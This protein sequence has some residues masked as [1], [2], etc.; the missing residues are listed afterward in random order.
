MVSCTEEFYCYLDEFVFDKRDAWTKEEQQTNQ[1]VPEGDKVF[2]DAAITARHDTYLQDNKPTEPPYEQGGKR[3]YD[4]E[5]VNNYLWNDQ[6]GAWID[7][8]RTGPQGPKGQDGS[9]RILISIDPPVA[10]PNGEPLES[11]DI[12]FNNCSAETWIYYQPDKDVPGNWLSFGTGGIQGQQGPIGNYQAIIGLCAP[13]ERPSGQPLENGDI[14]FNTC[15]GEAFWYFDGQ[16]IN[17]TAN[18][19]KGDT[20]FLKLFV[21]SLLQNVEKMTH[22]YSVVTSGSTPVLVRCM[23]V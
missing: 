1:V 7:Y 22:L 21:L 23:S 15:I 20:G 9:Y 14:W 12:W 10:R 5:K 6:I 18:G 8:A 17:F 13:E 4:T 19:T 11:G 3:W 2:T 16:W